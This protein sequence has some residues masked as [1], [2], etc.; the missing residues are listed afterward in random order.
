MTGAV[1]P[2]AYKGQSCMDSL[3]YRK[4]SHLLYHLHLA[5]KSHGPWHIQNYGGHCCKEADANLMPGAEYTQLRN[6]EL[7][8]VPTLKINIL[9]KAPFPSSAFCSTP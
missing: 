1:E 5:F 3:F 6:Y 2:Q 9:I 8:S 4:D 7:Q